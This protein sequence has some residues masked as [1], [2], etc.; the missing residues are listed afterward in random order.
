MDIRSFIVHTKTDDI[1]KHIAEDVKTRFG[2]SNYEFN[3]PLPKRKDTK[4]IGVMKD[5]LGG[6]IMKEFV[7][8][9]ARTYSHLTDD[10]SED[11][12]VKS[13]QKLC[14]NRKLRFENYKNCLEAT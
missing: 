7:G 3:R 1:Y 6:Q 14:H 13:T 5:G 4:V 11:K 9:K 2:T 8:L 12:N 10:G